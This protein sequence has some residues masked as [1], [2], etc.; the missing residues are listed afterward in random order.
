MQALILVGGEATR[1]RPLTCN[2]PKAMV[3]VLNSPFLEHV[4]RYLRSYDVNNIV[5]AQGYLPKMMDDYFGDGTRFATRLTYSLETKPMNTAGA[6]KNA[7]SYLDQRFLVLNGDIFT[8]LNIT[9]MIKFHTEMKA[10]VTIALTPV[11]DPTAYG[12]IETS[13]VGKVT[14]FLEKPTPEQVTT[15]MINAG[16]YVIEREILDWVPPQTNYSFERQLFPQL[17]QRGEPVYA[18]SSPAYWIDIGKAETYFKL[19]RDLLTGKVKGYNEAQGR[20]IT[21]GPGCNIHP[22][23]EIT[24]PAVIGANCAVG[25]GSRLV[26]PV[27]LGTGIVVGENCLIDTSILWENSRLAPGV[28]LKE[29][30]IANDCRLGENVRAEKAVIGDHIAVNRNSRLGPGSQ[31]WP[32][33]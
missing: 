29:C 26:G 18:F 6:V 21:T 11:A 3:P 10:K 20:A 25:K 14:R 8:D 23:A 33:A 1:L 22:D 27:V 13:P 2:M 15:N 28:N 9:A 31:L 5:L 7:E 24:G 4:I 30:L 16:T 12:L 17:L 19:H 32:P